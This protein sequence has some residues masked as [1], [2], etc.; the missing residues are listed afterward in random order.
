MLIM[1]KIINKFTSFINKGGKRT[2]L[3][4]RN[5]LFS[6]L[7]K[8]IGMI[9]MFMLVPISI[10]YLGETNY[11]IWI[12][13][14]GI[15]AWSG[16]FDFGFSHGLRN[17]LTEA[18]AK[19]KYEL[20]KSLISTT[21]LFLFLIA[22]MIFSILSILIEQLNWSLLLSLPNGYNIEILKNTLYIISLF[23]IFQFMLKPINA[24]L[25]ALQ[26]PAISQAFG[27]LGG[28]IIILS[29]LNLP[30]LGVIPNLYLYAFI[31]AGTP[32]LILFLGSLYMYIKKYR[33]LMPSINSINLKYIRSIGGLGMTFFFIQLSLLIVYSSDNLII[34]YLFGPEE[35]TTYNVVYRY[36]SIITIFFGV[37]M[38]PFWSAITDAYVKN[39]MEWIKKTIQSLL[40]VLLGG[41]LISI[42]LSIFAPWVFHWWIGNDFFVS[43]LLIVLMAI[44]SIL[45]GLLNIFSF[46]SNGIGKIRIQ[47]IAYI[48][49]AIINIPLSYFFGKILNMGSSGVLLSTIIC[50]SFINLILIIQYTKIINNKATGLWYK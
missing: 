19:E 38:S 13:I 49:S 48:I 33:Y 46:F 20:S 17:K 22:L 5:I 44:Y 3:I 4:K 30:I 43:S 11:G 9:T 27:T 42:I 29:I 34:S 37:I 36:F 24:I 35:V 10:D 21:Y 15:I 14:S 39:E 47:L 26:L 7:L 25:Q 6:L 40:L 8:F 12:T 1:Y 23:F 45:M 31:V 32:V 41:S 18:I 16:M 28:L 50:M 2:I